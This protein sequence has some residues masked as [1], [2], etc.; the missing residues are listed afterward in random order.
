MENEGERSQTRSVYMSVREAAER[1]GSTDDLIAALRAGTV[2][3]GNATRITDAQLDDDWQWPGETVPLTRADW[4]HEYEVED[5]RIMIRSNPSG[6]GGYLRHPKLE[7]ASVERALKKRDLGGRPAALATHLCWLQVIQRLV[8]DG[9]PGDQ[10]ELLAMKPVLTAEMKDWAV[11]ENVAI[12]DRT[13]ERIVALFCER[14]VL[15]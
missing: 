2:T 12:E 10:A 5:D 6:S 1:F 11:A 4:D 14:L 15:R 8:D 9:M 7:R 3:P 13:I